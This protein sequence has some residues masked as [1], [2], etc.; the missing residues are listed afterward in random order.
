M[1]TIIHPETNINIDIFSQEGR[2]ILDKY[3]Q[4]YKGG[5]FFTPKDKPKE[6]VLQINLNRI[7]GIC[8]QI[9]V[10]INEAHGA[11]WNNTQKKWVASWEQWS[12]RG[13]SFIKQEI[14]NACAKGV[15]QEDFEDITKHDCVYASAGVKDYEKCRNLFYKRFTDVRNWDILDM[16]LLISD[17]SSVTKKQIGP[18]KVY[19]SSK[20]PSTQVIVDL[21]N[22]GEL[23]L[24]NKRNL[25]LE[26]WDTIPWSN[27]ED[28]SK[29]KQRMRHV[30]DKINVVLSRVNLELKGGASE[31]TEFEDSQKLY[32]V[33]DNRELREKGLSKYIKNIEASKK[34]YQH[35]AARTAALI[36]KDDASKKSKWQD[37]IYSEVPADTSE[38][39]QS[40]GNKIN[41]L[42]KK[43]NITRSTVTPSGPSS[44]QLPSGPAIGEEISES[45]ATKILG[46]K[47]PVA[48]P[49]GETSDEKSTDVESEESVES[50]EKKDDE[51]VNVKKEEESGDDVDSGGP[52]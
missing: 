36:G 5:K 17:G 28:L 7:P 49:V 9:K 1:N 40:F 19:K 42:S 15:T 35:R 39:V 21:Y 26:W 3:I 18:T 52:D 38:S 10:I 14:V 45:E 25:F 13:E 37:I 47:P 27:K 32:V 43:S 48:H 23:E 46:H 12:S 31:S 11:K 34:K 22:N 6:V 33:V 4:I 51:E 20:S 41:Q 50:E 8:L 30:G 2:E 44:P 29:H 24:S 16:Y